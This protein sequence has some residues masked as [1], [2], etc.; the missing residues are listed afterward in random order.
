MSNKTL[1]SLVLIIGLVLIGANS[2]FTINQYEKG[3]SKMFGKIERNE[4][5]TPKL[6]QPGI[7]FKV[8]FL[9]SV[10]R[11]DGRIQTL[12]GAADRVGTLEK[13]DL[14][15]DTFVKWRIKDFATYYL[16]TQGRVTRANQLLETIVKSALLAEF[17]KH[18][19]TDAIYLKRDEM[20]KNISDAANLGAP[21]FGI[22]IVDV[23]VKQ[24][25][26]PT[27]VNENIYRQM[28]AERLQAATKERSEGQKK[29]TIIRAEAQKTVV[30]IAANA[31][32]K[33]RIVRSEADAK[34]A[35]IYATSFKKN[36]EFYDF[37]RSLE[38][39]RNTFSSGN[40]VMVIS[41]DDDFFR[42]FGKEKN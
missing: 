14:M 1:Y 9:E 30:V 7:H 25:N 24:A 35:N 40:D 13:I 6:Y 26:Y 22:E 38:A 33:A 28:R 15:V 4:D 17:G 10:I 41:P 42:Y 3:L 11:L 12:D 34:S 16:R 31:G 20:L 37:L 27:D 5:G 18:S 23:R 39:Y 8:P 21:E 29:A 2:F 36:A 19:V 32:L